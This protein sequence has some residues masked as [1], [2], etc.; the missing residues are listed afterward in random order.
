[1]NTVV[2]II[3]DRAPAVVAASGE[4]ASYRFFEFVTAQIRNPHRRVPSRK[5]FL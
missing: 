3:A 4:R 1:M 5:G 2:A